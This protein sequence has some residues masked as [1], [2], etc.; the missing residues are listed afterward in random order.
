MSSA[1]RL[2]GLNRMKTVLL[3]MAAVVMTLGLVEAAL[4]LG[5]YD[6]LASW[7]NGRD[8]ILRPS[9]NPDLKYELTPGASG[10]AWGTDIRINSQGFRGPEP[11][12]RADA[13][14]RIIVLGDSIT[15]G[16]HLREETT[17]PRLLEGHLRASGRTT[18]VL[19][20]GVGGYDVLQEVSLLASRP[21]YQPTL[22]VLAYCLNDAGIA[23][24]SRE[25]IRHL[26]T[27]R[28]SLLYRSVLAQFVSA[29]IERMRNFQWTSYENRSDVFHRAYEG[30][31]DPIG[32]DETDLLDLM[33][34]APPGQPYEWYRDRD[35]VGR[36]RLAFRRLAALSHAGSFQVLVAIL[37]WLSGDGSGDPP[38]VVH[39]IV[40][41]EARRAGLDTVDLTGPF[42]RAGMANL[43][44]TADDPIHPNEAGHALIAEVLG[45]YVRERSI[46]PASPPPS[47]R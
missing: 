41:R 8:L 30:Q 5:G 47:P 12:P 23:S 18:E 20:F 15:F 9:A 46:P 14:G 36:V 26:E 10:F 38:Q 21:E 24:A 40:A 33:K 7:R 45:R 28:S 27:Y 3:S 13:A 42:E 43:R 37:P 19:N 32:D 17:F 11:R 34:A 35:R 6:A 44:M 4:R 22:V 39:Q 29:R 25:Y 31:I 2:T 16:H 1:T